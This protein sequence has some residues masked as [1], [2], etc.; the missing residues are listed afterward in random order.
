[1]LL[2]IWGLVAL[3]FNCVSYHCLVAHCFYMYLYLLVH[4]VNIIIYMD[5]E[6]EIN[7]YITITPY[8]MTAMKM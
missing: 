4:I 2:Y 5:H 1:M 3:Y 6:S 8:Q 7:I